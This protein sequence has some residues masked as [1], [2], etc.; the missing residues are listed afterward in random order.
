[1]GF[2]WD[3]FESIVLGVLYALAS[4]TGELV[5]FACTLGRHRITWWDLPDSEISSSS[6]ILGIVVWVAVGALLLA[7]L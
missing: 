6:W 3:L 1:M 7:L 4:L 5:R 2:L